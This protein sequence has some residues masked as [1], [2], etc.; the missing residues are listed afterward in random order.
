MIT[1]TESTELTLV[2]TNV[3]VYAHDQ[4]N[5]YHE[6]CR[7]LLIEIGSLCVVP[8]SIAEFFA[9]VTSSRRVT[10]PRSPQDAVKV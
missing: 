6:T 9:I 5:P 8:Q 2:D 1:S 7:K 4:G 3:L 10:R